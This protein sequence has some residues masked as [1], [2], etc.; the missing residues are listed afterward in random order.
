MI[1]LFTF[2]F[3]FQ[4]TTLNAESEVIR[5]PVRIDGQIGF[6]NDR[7][8]LAIPARFHAAD[9]F[10]NGLTPVRE[11]GLYG[12]IDLNGDYVLPPAYEFAEPFRNGLARVWSEGKQQTIDQQGCAIFVNEHAEVFPFNGHSYA[13]VESKGGKYGLINRMG[14]LLVDTILSGHLSLEPKGNGYFQLVYPGDWQK[15]TDEPSAIV[16]PD[17]RITT[18]YNGYAWRPVE[19][20][21]ASRKGVFPIVIHEVDWSTLRSWSSNDRLSHGGLVSADGEEIVDNPEWEHVSSFTD[22]RAFVY[23]YNHRYW[24]IDETGQKLIDTSFLAV[25]GFDSYGFDRGIFE[26]GVAILKRGRY[27]YRLDWDLNL[28]R[29][30]E[31]GPGVKIERSG[32]LLF[33]KR[34]TN[35]NDGDPYGYIHGWYDLIREKLIAPQ[36]AAKISKVDETDLLTTEIDGQRVFLDRGP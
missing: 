17:G 5:I 18:K 6:I 30:P 14:K 28:T 11:T 15:D 20:R 9:I 21:C 32:D 25:D 2:L 22:G 26:D 29:L 12:Y 35:N 33:L 3:L 23:D 8:E 34:E 7:G 27:W 19:G 4:A 36:Y 13:S 16:G 24:L 10:A 1:Y 31:F